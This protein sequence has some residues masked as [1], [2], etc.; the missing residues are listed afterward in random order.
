MDAKRP[1]SVVKRRVASEAVES[2]LF[3]LLQTPCEPE[4]ENH[5][6]RRQNRNLATLGGKPWPAWGG[7]ERG[8]RVLRP[9]LTNRSR[10]RAKGLSSSLARPARRP[11]DLAVSGRFLPPPP[12]SSSTAKLLGFSSTWR[13]HPPA[14]KQGTAPLPPP[15]LFPLPPQPSAALFLVERAES[16]RALLFASLWWLWCSYSVLV[17]LCKCVVD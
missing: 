6:Q 5:G 16:E 3:S 2:T 7:K 10:E 14:G 12:A 9:R 15:G 4:R 13:L 17:V 8:E 11:P 1:K